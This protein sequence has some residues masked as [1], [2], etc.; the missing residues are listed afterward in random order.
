MLHVGVL[1]KVSMACRDM[2]GEE[3]GTID[4]N[5]EPLTERQ[6]Y[7]TK[8]NSQGSGRDGQ[9]PG[10]MAWTGVGPPEPAVGRTQWLVAVHD[11]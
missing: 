3:M 8:W 9:E 7:G 1:E 10:K 2:G 11:A 5:I 6:T 4:G